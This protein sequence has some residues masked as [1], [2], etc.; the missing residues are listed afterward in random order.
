MHAECSKLS[1][2]SMQWNHVISK[3]ANLPKSRVL[4]GKL[5]LMTHNKTKKLVILKLKGA[6]HW[7]IWYGMIW[8]WF[9]LYTLGIQS[10]SLWR[11]NRCLATA[12]FQFGLNMQLNGLTEIREN[13]VVLCHLAILTEF[14]WLASTSIQLQVLAKNLL[15][16][17]KTTAHI[18]TFTMW[19]VPYDADTQSYPSKSSEWRFLRAVASVF[20]FP[21]Y[22]DSTV[23]EIISQAFEEFLV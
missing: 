8:S 13:S 11:S 5:C 17:F 7:L 20:W 19:M 9:Q 6:D 1:I 3:V 4:F 16:Y 14:Q 15:K 22:N 21:M 2:T 10:L 12:H 23:I 18:C